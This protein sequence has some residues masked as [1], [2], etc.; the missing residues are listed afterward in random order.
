MKHFP[1]S[2]QIK[3]FSHYYG[4]MKALIT[5]IFLVFQTKLFTTAFRVMKAPTQ[6][7]ANRNKWVI[8]PAL[9]TE[10]APEIA[11]DLMTRKTQVFW[12][13]NIPIIKLTGINKYKLNNHVVTSKEFRESMVPIQVWNDFRQADV[14]ETRQGWN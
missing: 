4:F 11:N 2:L 10:L 8:S 6:L 7:T 5:Q 13:H 9:K 14:N 12:L 3:S 1:I